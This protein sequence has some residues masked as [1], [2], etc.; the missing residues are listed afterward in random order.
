M[1]PRIITKGFTLIE[2]TIVLIVMGLILGGVIKT[3]GVQ[4][5][6]LKRDETRQIL[7]NIN[8]ALI[9]FA[10][11]EGRLPCPDTD[12]DGIENPQNPD[13]TTSCDDDEGFLP[14]VDIGVGGQDAWGNGLRYRV[15]GTGNLSFANLPPAIDGGGNTTA[16]DAS[17]SMADNGNIRIEDRGANL[18]ANDIPA[19][20]ISY[21]ENGRRTIAG[22]FPCA[23]NFPSSIE[24]ENCNDDTT[25]LDDDY[26]SVT[27]AGYDDL[28]MW[29]SLT[30]LKSRMLEAR[31]LP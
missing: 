19:V 17:F 24:D 7:Q 1:T 29:V 11:T 2:I 22:G 10:T 28:V 18:I 13:N 14:F 4:R 20:V 30:V 23:A 21:G 5:Q 16:L 6:Q 25:F 31:R 26:S 8:Q 3:V 12:G 9:G 15:R 27:A